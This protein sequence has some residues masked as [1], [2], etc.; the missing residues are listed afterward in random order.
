MA[1]QDAL[2]SKG[3]TSLVLG[4]IGLPVAAIVA[5]AV[6]AKTG[7][8]PAT[9][10]PGAVAPG[11][12]AAES[13]ITAMAITM[14][15]LEIVL[16]AGPAF[17]VDARRRRRDLALVAASGGAERHLRAVVLA[18]GVLLGGIAAV[19]GALLG[20]LAAAVAMPIVEA[21]QDEPLGP[22]RMPWAQVAVTMLF[23]LGSGAL[24]A[25]LPARQ[26]AR[27]DVVAALAGRRD[28]PGRARRGWPIAGGLLVL[29][30]VAA[31][32]LG[33]RVLNEFGA[34]FGAAAIIA[35]LVA[36]CPWI[37]GTAGRLAPRLPLPLRLAVRD[38]ARNRA[39]TA[40]AVAAIMAA[41][42]G[43]TALAIGGASDLRQEQIEYQARLPAGSTMIRA[44][45]TGADAAEQAI[46]RDLPGVPV[47]SLKTLPGPGGYCTGD[48]AACPALSF[49]ARE[50]PEVM[51]DLL[52]HLVGGPR[53]A[54]MLLGRD[55]PAVTSALD[56]GKV[57]LFGGSPTA[58]GTTAATV[59]EW[60]DAVQR[61]TR[62]IEGLPAVA[63][64][65]DPHVRAIVPPKVA[66]R[67]GM[68]IR[69]EAFG[70]DRADH[71]VTK[72]EQARL[73]RT[74]R[75]FGDDIEDEV[76][77]ERGFTRTFGGVMALLAAV[78]GVLALGGALIATS[79]A[80]A[81]SRP[82]LATF[83]AV[84]ARPG[85]RRLLTMGQAAFVAGLGCWLGIA[86]GVVP[87]LAAARPLTNQPGQPGVAGHGTILDVPWTLLIGLGVVIPLVT[88][89]GVGTFTRGRLP[90]TR[91]ALS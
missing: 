81:D 20:T 49:V 83:A 12:S 30:G 19:A 31:S 91:R 62:R 33:V 53:E 67:I 61:T 87:G 75:A 37:V 86:G 50:D 9:G 82:D 36:A 63:A 78:A 48:G 46:R 66:E 73:E 23:G 18:T 84:G 57:V 85:T 56:A 76:Y 71:R 27:M 6:L 55:D 90:M 65:G 64:S 8:E 79:L 88:A 17:V 40:P 22:F 58:G 3:R 10:T 51:T 7:E 29:A 13:A 70:V 25:L 72:A 54:R 35:G 68:P 52:D 4:M 15:V 59:F 34:A 2:R 89:V 11:P 38:G 77:V 24:A 80:A 74:M 69:T 28:P 5:L 21:V 26:A 32:L 42:A 39:R 1:R 60:D 14:I 16:L 43:I 41:V 44:P 45:Q 47:L